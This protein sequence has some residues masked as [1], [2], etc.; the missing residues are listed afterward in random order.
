M[1]LC[2]T[3]ECRVGG[4]PHPIAPASLLLQSPMEDGTYGVTLPPELF[5]EDAADGTGGEEGS[6]GWLPGAGTHGTLIPTRSQSPLSAAG[7]VMEASAHSVASPYAFLVAGGSL[8]LGIA[9]FV[10]IVVR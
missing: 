8:L 7:A 4:L 10:G 6:M 9:L 2:G 5:G 1:T 3:R